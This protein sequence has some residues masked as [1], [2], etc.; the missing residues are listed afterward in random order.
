[1][2]TR[3]KFHDAIAYIS[4][5]VSQRLANDIMLRVTTVV[6][7]RDFDVALAAL[8]AGMSTSGAGVFVSNGKA[9]RTALRALLLC[10]GVYLAPPAQ[11]IDH[12]P[13]IE[14]GWPQ[15]TVNEWKSRSETEI[16]RAIAMY[17]ALPGAD[18]DALI[19]AASTM[20]PTNRDV[21]LLNRL[22]SITRQ[23]V[24]FPIETTCY[25]AVQSWLLASGFVSM[26]WFLSSGVSAVAGAQTEVNCVAAQLLAIFPAGRMVDVTG[27]FVLFDHAPPNPGDIVY[28]Y[29]SNANG[30]PKAGGQLG[31]WMVA[32]RGG[33]AYGCNNFTDDEAA[34]TNPTYAECN[35]KNQIRA[36]RRGSIVPNVA[37]AHFI[38]IFPPG[39]IE[40][41]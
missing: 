32:G 39:T 14:G 19:V 6:G 13:L 12:L 25:R 40:A 15:G 11:A 7:V 41:R 24:P 5:N 26:R 37:D 35:L 1:M 30:T 33:L 2:T 27:D 16:K 28:M 23:D 36:L 34:G 10:Q 29:R 9:R 3:L 21:S 18:A 31:H 17:M 20:P 38:R 4:Q 8:L 22:H